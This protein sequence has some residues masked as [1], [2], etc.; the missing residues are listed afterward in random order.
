MQH[1]LVTGVPGI[2]KTTL[3]RR[4]VEN[5]RTTKLTFNGF[6]T[7]DIRVSED[8]RFEKAGVGVIRIRPEGRTILAHKMHHPVGPRYARLGSYTI[9]VKNFEDLTLPMLH[10]FQQGILIIEI[11]RMQLCSRKFEE[12]IPLL[13]NR[14]NVQVL[15]IVPNQGP[16]MVEKLKRNNNTKVINVTLENRDVLSREIFNFFLYKK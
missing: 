14:Q 10:S 11:G 15:A 12:A 8:E 1:I 9:Y 2:G 6:L 13:F 5:L 4:I 3:I 16:E 7:E